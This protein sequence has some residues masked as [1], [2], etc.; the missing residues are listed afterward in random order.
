[1]LADRRYTSRMIIRA[2]TVATMDGP[3]IEDGAVAISGNRIIDV[4][5]FPG[6]SAR[7][8]LPVYVAR[9]PPA[10]LSMLEDLMSSRRATPGKLS[11]LASKRSCPG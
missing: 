6:V 10:P 4:G 11:I 2:R 1:M 8:G 7:H 3:P 5:E 9:L